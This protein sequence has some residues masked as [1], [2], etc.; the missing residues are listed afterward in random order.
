MEQ[1]LIGLLEN[2]VKKNWDSDSLSD[3]QGETLKGK[4]IATQIA[5][6]HILFE[7]MGIKRGDK[8]ALCGR[9]TS[10]WC[11]CFLS[12]I[13]YGAVAVPI[14]HEFKPEQIHNIVNHS[15]ARLLF[16]GD[17][18][19]KSLDGNLMPQL[20]G[21][22]QMNDYSIPFLRNDALSNFSS[23]IEETFNKK[24][25]KGFTVDDV[26][27]TPEADENDVALINYTSGTTSF[28]KGVLLPYRA[29][30]SNI[31]FGF[32]NLTLY[33]SDNIVSMLPL[34]HMYGLLY[35][36]LFEFC[37]G[38]HVW[39]L[40]RVPSPKI[41][42]QAFAELKPRLIVA[43]PLIIEKVMRTKIMPQLQTPKMRLLLHL[44]VVGYFVRRKIRSK[45]IE[46]FGGKFFEIIV[47]GA[48]FN[49]EVEKMLH[50]LRF[51]YSVGYGMTECAPLVCYTIWNKFVPGSCGQAVDRMKVRVLSRDPEHV[52]GE[53]IVKG[54]NV[55]LGYYKNEEA[56]RLAID[57]Q[58]WLHT[59]DLGIIDSRGNLFIR[60]RS[61]NMIL[62]PSGQNIYPEELEEK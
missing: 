12:A 41:I 58:G 4:Q 37:S 11:V 18:V 34:A 1:T 28:S 40:T 24:Y 6:M 22:I 8:V 38:A 53:I 19:W 56:T 35:E 7:E 16:A 46:A 17:I 14:L 59:G 51:P 55:M 15:D 9:N 25:P 10:N 32:D 47:G 52:V 30:I 21:V 33:K 61:K 48:G 42:F 43:V 3:Y 57:E 23:T 31:V 5:K 60:G 62:G 2:N 20:D 36:F 39:F 49:P 29:L 27:Y 44:P 54:D 45:M 50:M 26:R 13:T